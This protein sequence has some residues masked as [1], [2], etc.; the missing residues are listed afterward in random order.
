VFLKKSGLLV[1]NWDY[2]NAQPYPPAVWEILAIGSSSNCCLEPMPVALCHACRG[3]RCRHSKRFWLSGS[4]PIPSSVA[5]EHR[6]PSSS[7]LAHGRRADNL[8]LPRLLALHIHPRRASS[9][10]ACYPHALRG[11]GAATRREC[12]RRGGEGAAWEEGGG[13]R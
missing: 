4:H 2:R 1:V 9:P 5:A 7:E 3:G 10:P 13:G 8:H 11:A 6:A 12:G